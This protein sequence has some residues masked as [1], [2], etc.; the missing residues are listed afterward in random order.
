MGI[1]LKRRAS[2][3]DRLAQ[4]VGYISADFEQ[5]GAAFLDAL[6]LVPMSHAGTNLLGYPVAGVVDS[7]SDDGRIAAEYSDRK[8]YFGGQMSKAKGDLLKAMASKPSATDIF[9]LAGDR[10]RP[11]IAQ[12]FETR[13]QR[14]PQMQ[15][16]TLHLWGSEEIAERLIDELIVSDT[17]VRRLASYLPE[18]Q[19]LRDEEAV[20]N[21]A[22][23]PD[24][25]YLA[26]S[27]VDEEISARLKADGGIAISGMGG[28]GKSAA[29]AAYANSHED[30][31]DLVI[32]LEGMGV[33]SIQQLHSMPLDRGGE[34]RNIAALLRTRA[35]LL[36]ID[37]ADPTLTVPALVE[38]CGQGSHVILTQRQAS[39]VSYA[40]PLMQQ[41]LAKSL[42]NQDVEPCPGEVFQTIWQTVNGH[43]LS[44][45][46]MNA[47]VR[48]GTSWSEIEADC[49]AVGEM[50]DG[51]QRL[52]DRLLGR[53]WPALERE[54]SVFAWAGQPGCGRDF[55]ET[56]ILP[57]GL[58]KLRT[59]GLMSADRPEVARLHDVVFGALSARTWCRAERDRELDGLFE[60]YLIQVAGEPGLRFWTICRIMLQKLERLV[61][62]GS[63]P[64]IFR[65]ALLAV[66]DTGE[67]RLELIPDP[68]EEAKGLRGAKPPLFAVIAVIEAIEQLFL[69]DKTDGDDVAA[70]RLRERLAAF[71]LLADL[72]DLS[73]LE[74]AQVRHHKAKALKRLGETREA[75][76]LFEQV[77]KG[78]APL[79]E[80]RLQLID[81][82]RTN[83][84]TAPRAVAL[85]DDILTQSAGTEE[86]SYSVFLGAVERLPWGGGAWRSDLF[87]KHAD[88]IANT[89][90]DAAEMGV[91]Q[92]Y[93]T[94]GAIGRYLSTEQPQL[95][96]SIFSRLTRPT[97]E[98]L[99]SDN[100]KAS[101]GEIYF[102]ASRLPGGERAAL[103]NQAL[104]F[105]SAEV[106]PQ[107][108]HLQRKAEL[109]IDMGRAADAEA[110]LRARKDLNSSEW[111]ERLMARAR[112]ARG[113]PADALRWIDSALERLTA[114]H[115]RSE[116]LELRYDI[117][118]A[119]GDKDAIEDLKA[120]LVASQKENEALR[121][122]ERLSD[123]GGA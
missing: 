91:Q 90:I 98:S 107:P 82:Y 72:P 63:R 50:A 113:D 18:L 93:R 20:S 6:L 121:L 2:Q 80:T 48:Q 4:A 88:V 122:G 17:V 10:K 21:L 30:D 32:W 40:L 100:D 101:W 22:P 76:E 92:A 14:L 27:L 71:D 117:R 1:H 104:A 5:F 105:Y 58:R 11:Q 97:P 84:D 25:A 36:V 35:C 96:D 102:E 94:F 12:A 95:F 44:L 33:T 69:H 66:W 118:H 39:A 119:L 34:Q 99:S 89:I 74:T 45:A 16:R 46:L 60:A 41:E 62:S 81:I 3:I 28:L 26:R 8:G 67:L 109:L 56:T 52:A 64:A 77:L 73:D 114:E 108:F 110:I 116:F 123:H 42:L 54:L 83:K 112:L 49:Q 55:L 43:P 103:Q 70:R 7:V 86:V 19:R 65:Y 31:Y 38:L 79:S 75:A 15:G 78:S 111:I 53:L 51:T 85:V 68:V 87:R 59:N 57:L 61:A 120:A 106:A 24:R 23:L 13:M 9:L 47:V 29:S 37:D 115:F